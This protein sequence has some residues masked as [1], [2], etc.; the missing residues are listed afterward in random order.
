MP[1]T[2]TAETG[3]VGLAVQTAF[4]TFREPT[5]YMKVLSIEMN[6]EGE[7]IIPDVEIGAGMDVTEVHQGTYRIS[8]DLESY[9]RPEA[10]GV[11]MYGLL[12][13]YTSSGEI[14]AGQGNYLHNFLPITSGSLPW[15]SV[16]KV[17]SDNVQTY[18]YRDC[19]VGSFSL[20]LKAGEF[21]N[22]KFGIVGI[23][24]AAGTAGTPSFETAPLLV[25][26]KATINMGPASISAKNLT[27]DVN[28]SLVDDDF[29]IGS[30]F[31]GDI[32]EGRRSLEV[33]LDVVLDTTS[34]LYKKAFY[35]A[36]NL[37]AAGFDV[38][39][40]SLDIVMDSPTLIGSSAMTYKVLFQIKRAVFVSAPVPAKGDDLVVVPL[41]LKP[42]KYL[43]NNILEVH[44]WNNKSAYSF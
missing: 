30:R 3:Y 23:A 22:A 10:F 21:A 18:N 43:T 13:R 1:S 41:T 15:I 6:P 12:G 35:G 16:K 11:L 36:S 2:F 34:E 17:I 32:S 26:T 4:G 5:D 7:K 29:R 20:E 33:N 44:I 28:N 31:L 8:G 42:V 38:Y 24:D 27:L 40:D 39:A 19:K 25:A 37:S 9:I 14:N